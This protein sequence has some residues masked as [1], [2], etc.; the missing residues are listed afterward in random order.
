MFGIGRDKWNKS[1]FERLL[2]RRIQVLYKIAYSY[3]KDQQIASDALQDSVLLAF[4]SIDKLKDKEKF[5]AWITT[6]LVNRCREIL[7][8]NK[9]VKYEELND[10]IVILNNSFWKTNECDYSKI[11]TKLDMLNLINKLDEKHR[12]AIR[13]KYIGDYTLKE[14]AA[15]LDIPLGTVKSRLSTGIEKLRE[16]MEVENHVV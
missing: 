13:L 14:I 8:K 12:E 4:R 7:R 1:E 11:D 6:I 2:E 3:F 9:G 5:D 10:N 15:V 16:L